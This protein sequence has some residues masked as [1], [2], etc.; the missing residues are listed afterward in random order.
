MPQP[1]R[2]LAALL[3]AALIGACSPAERS[4]PTAP[5]APIIAPSAT[6][7]P[8]AAPAAALPTTILP[9][10]GSA[11]D[12][13][14]S[15]DSWTPGNKQGVGTAFT[16]DQP[17]GDANPSRVWFGITDGAITEGLYPDVSRANI[18]SLGVLVSDGTSFLA[19]ETTDA[20]YAIA[21]LDARTPAYRV[22]STDKGGRWAVT[23]EIVADPQA[24]TILFT[25]VFTALQ[26]QPEDYHLFLSYTPRIGQSGAGDLSQVEGGVA[27]AWDAQ[28]GVYTALAAD[29]APALLTTGY[30]RKND[31]AAD[32]KDFKVDAA[33]TS[34]S[35]PGRL[36]IGAELPVR[37]ATTVAL[38]F[39]KGQARLATQPPPASS[40]VLRPF[41]RHICRA[42]PAT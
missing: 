35:V 20:T 8:T 19:D 25:V 32:L 29:P 11:P 12:Q 6:P 33:Y 2:T 17:A 23:K 30:T 38:G 39:G 21:R 26:G 4:I 18:K 22:T 1:T 13:P 34:T 15:V 42:G 41:R 36:T 5:P 9:S 14:I 7:A 31:L 40:V 10:A 24:N 37:G 3:L 16:Y 28:A 27:E